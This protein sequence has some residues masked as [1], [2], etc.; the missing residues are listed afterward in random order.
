MSRYNGSLTRE[1]FM[2]REIRI[3][4]QLY[5]MGLD[6]SQIVNKVMEENLFQYPTEREIKGKCRVALRRLETIASSTMLLEFLAEGTLREAKQA[7]L[8]AMMCDSRLLADFMVEVVG[9]KYRR[10]ELTLTKKD[11]NLFFEQ[12]CEL[13]QTVADWSTSTVRRIQSVLMNVLR[14][15]GYLEGIG[16]EELIPVLISNDF[17]TALRV[18]GLQRFLPAFNILE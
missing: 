18:A 7:A 12:L 17:E 11:V 1:Q 2:F 13:D 9:E 3:V 16:S 8:V 6:S 5:R 14:E 15:N 4:A 10:L